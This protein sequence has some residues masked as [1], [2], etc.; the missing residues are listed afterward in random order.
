[1]PNEAKFYADC[2]SLVI[3]EFF[4]RKK[5]VCWPENS[6]YLLMKLKSR[7]FTKILPPSW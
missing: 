3:I 5:S 7:N 2:R 6:E 1:M 4:K